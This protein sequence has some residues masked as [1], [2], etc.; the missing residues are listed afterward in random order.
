[1]SKAQSAEEAQ[2]L[3]AVYAG[4]KLPALPGVLEK[5]RALGLVEPGPRGF[6][7]TRDG[8]KA[9]RQATIAAAR[10]EGEATTA[11]G[12]ERESPPPEVPAAAS[13]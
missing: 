6:V 11:E 12:R 8:E 3:M 7:L 2:M 9:A 5:L 1:M 13:D 4:Q 10:A